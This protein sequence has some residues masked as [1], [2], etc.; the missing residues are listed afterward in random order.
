MQKELQTFYFTIITPPLIFFIILYLA[1]IFDVMFKL[2]SGSHYIEIG[3]LGMAVLLAF[4]VPMW[5]RI[6]FV[7]K[8]KGRRFVEKELFM[9]FQKSFLM[10]SQSTLYIALLAFYLQTSKWIMF[11]IVLLTLYA[12]YFYYPSEKRIES[13][14]KL[15][16]VRE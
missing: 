11:T 5:Y 9:K 15:F 3:L 4:V 6:L 10:I 16:K 8:V 7:K 1:D 12:L 13:E 2:G 14:K